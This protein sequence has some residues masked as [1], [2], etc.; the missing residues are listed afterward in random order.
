MLVRLQQIMAQLTPEED[1]FARSLFDEISR[2]DM[3]SWIG[4]L[5]AMSVPEAVGYVR[6][7]FRQARAAAGDTEPVRTSAPTAPTAPTAPR[8]AGHPASGSDSSESGTA[9]R[10]QADAS[11]IRRPMPANDGPALRVRVRRRT[12]TGSGALSADERTAMPKHFAAS[13][14][15]DAAVRR[16]VAHAAGC[17]CGCC[18]PR[19]G[20]RIGRPPRGEP[21]RGDAPATPHDR[22][23][24]KPQPHRVDA[25]S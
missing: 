11:P 21:C 7:M 8:R 25:R 12:S 24:R 14:R 6:D 13:R 23:G 15:E 20:G 9:R 5:R 2:E 4:R 18:R 3:A 1:Q 17:G 16:D 10:P 22:P 19:S